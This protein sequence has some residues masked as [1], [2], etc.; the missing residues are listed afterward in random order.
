MSG[1]RIIYADPPWQ[2]NNSNCRGAALKHYLTT[3]THA[4]EQLDVPSI[5]ADNAVLFMWATFPKLPDALTLI[6][7]WGF[8]YKSGAFTWVKQNKKADSLFMGLGSYTRANAEICLIATKGK[9]I[10]RQNATVRNT[11]IHRIGRHSEKPVAFR[12]DIEKLYGITEHNSHQ[13]PRLEMFARQA[14]P[15]WH[16]F[17]N[18]APQSITIPIQQKA[19]LQKTTQQETSQHG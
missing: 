14:A 19:P 9:G 8:T 17:G 4:L 16:V 3:S 2:Y 7:Q 5:T 13:F 10:P 12:H 1:Y 15:G 18:Q 11:Q 6:K